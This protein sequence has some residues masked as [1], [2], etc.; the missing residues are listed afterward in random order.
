MTQPPNCHHQ[1]GHLTFLP[2][3]LW[4]VWNSASASLF[5]SVVV[6]DHIGLR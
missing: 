6:L 4:Y 2:L 1:P 3:H 5:Y